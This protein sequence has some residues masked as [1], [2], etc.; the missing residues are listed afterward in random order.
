MERFCVRFSF[1]EFLPPPPLGG[2][3]ISSST[4]RSSIYT[5]FL[6]YFYI[7]VCRCR[8]LNIVQK[9]RYQYTDEHLKWGKSPTE[10]CLLIDLSVTVPLNI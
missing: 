10:I 8:C 4:L 1:R 2:G 7:H 5:L 3:G 6:L 9:Q